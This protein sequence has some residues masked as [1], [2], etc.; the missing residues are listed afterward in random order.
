MPLPNAPN[1]E[2]LG[3]L[4]QGAA[5]ESISVHFPRKV[6]EAN[7]NQQLELRG[8]GGRGL[9]KSPVHI[10]RATDPEMLA[11]KYR[12]RFLTLRAQ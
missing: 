6:A 7:V 1:N 2:R 8:S 11:T 3:E 12:S 9:G 10:S 5:A 4:C